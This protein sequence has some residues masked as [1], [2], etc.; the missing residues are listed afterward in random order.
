MS[1]LVWYEN[2]GW[3][4]HVLAG[5]QHRMINCVVVGDAIVLASEF[6]MQAAVAALEIVGGGVLHEGRR[7][8]GQ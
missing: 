4:R 1:E 2:P 5:G 7:R 6:S 3:Q 8:G